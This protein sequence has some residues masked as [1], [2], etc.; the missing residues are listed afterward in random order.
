MNRK[1]P[2][3]AVIGIVSGVLL[4]TA[5]SHALA[6]VP[7]PPLPPY[8]PVA[9]SYEPGISGLVAYTN[10]NGIALI[11]P[12][13]HTISPVLL[14][15]FD[16]TIDPDTGE[17]VGG[18]LGSEGGGRFDVA[19][20]SHGLEA[21]IS[22]FGDAKVFF[23]DLSSGT[24]VVAGVAEIDM[25]AEDVVID[26]TN[27][28][29][30]VTDGGFSARI[31]VL[32]LPTRAW[33]PAGV[34][35]VTSEPV[36]YSLPVDE[37]DP[38]DPVSRFA[39]AV[40]IA[41]DGRTV[42]VV[43]YFGGSIHVL[44]FDPATGDLAYQ[45]TV[46]LWKY[47]TDGNAAFPFLYRPVNVEISPDGRTVMVL[48][49]VRSTS[50]NPD[51]DPNAFYEGSNVPVFVIDQP[52]HVVRQPDVILPWRIGG[53]QS[54][55]FSRDGSKAYVETVYYD[56]EPDPIPDPLDVFW[57]YQEVQE[58][59]ITAPGVASLTN[60]VRMPTPRGTSQLFG[61]DTMAL[62]TDD[63]FLYVTNPTV[64]GAEP[65]I[66]VVELA[67]FTHVK[68]IGTPQH[69]PD[70]ARNWPDEPLPPDPD[71]PNDWIEEVLPVG[72]AFAQRPFP[73]TISKAFAAAT[74]P[75]NGSTTLTFTLTNPNASALSGVAF[76]DSLPAGMVVA[77]PNGA[78]GDCGGTITATAGATSISLTGASLAG[79]VTCTFSVNVTGT[80]AGLK[81][82]VT[83][84]VT[85]VES[86]AGTVATASVSVVAPP[87]IAQQFIPDSIFVGATT[88]LRFTISN[89]TENTVA[90]TGIAFGDTLPV[91][92]SVAS[93]SATMC[94]G[95]LTTTSPSG[96][97]LTG[98][99]VDVSGQ[100]QFDVV[101][102]G[103]ALG[104][105]TNTTDNVTSTNG[106]T[107]SPSSAILT[108]LSATTPV[109][110]LNGWALL[111]LAG[112]IALA[113]C[114]FLARG[115]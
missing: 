85:S 7:F 100:C 42:I 3:I 96:I 95:T 78:A 86:G 106:G 108:V 76:T 60:T 93:S 102:R 34:D 37:S 6:A 21:L 15:G 27:E 88:L 30:L 70:P 90:L 80:T 47:G 69:Y 44:L 9:M 12:V 45:Q 46:E 19:M 57:F 31:A 103:D 48:Q 99:T 75:L 53:A 22:N 41:P 111:I 16:Y 115:R 89:P 52:G 73:P 63:R 67:T 40:A 29:A 58:L 92:L 35:P 14:N 23:I 81:D 54:A 94:G 28:W 113:G 33:V 2:I 24:P 11:N 1:I 51:P 114:Q 105:F 20:T 109:P 25:F 97:A 55:V 49:V 43:D 62:T 72:I 87:T 79:N 4:A 61:V 39:Q 74:M 10:T 5:G 18:E 91:G 36:S 77:T 107:G 112:L 26:P 32:H 59:T 101:V 83:D 71:N 38:L 17:P 65:V 84:T 68:S 13:D 66:D 104:V 98:A 110:T 82:N 64:S 56:D 50:E 8:E